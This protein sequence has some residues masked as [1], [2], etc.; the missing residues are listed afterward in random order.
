[1]TVA[2]FARRAALGCAAVLGSA[3]LAACSGATGGTAQPAPA[4]AS[5]PADTSGA[6]PAVPKVGHP[7]DVSAYVGDPCRTVPPS[8]LTPLGYTTPG[9]PHT[10][11]AADTSAGPYCG[12]LI[13]AEGLSVQVGLLTGNR[14]R[15]TGGLSGLY[16]GKAAGQVGFLAPAPAVAGY[17]AVYTGLRDRRA[18]GDCGLDVGIADDL[19]FSVAAL[20]YQGEQDSCHV[21]ETV[22]AAVVGTLK[23][24]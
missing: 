10:A 18:R 9:E 4:S 6:N 23:G 24:A 19:V 20:G 22:A 8:V 17:P 11:A 16:Q 21:A 14:D 5:S 1:M 12:W 7:L 15:G 2:E 13:G 3:L